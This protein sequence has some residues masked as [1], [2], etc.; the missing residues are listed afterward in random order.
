VIVPVLIGAGFIVGVVV[1]RWL[2]LAPAVG[3]GAWIAIVSELDEVPGWLLG[4]WYGVI[5]CVSIGAGIG[6]RRAI[7]R[8]SRT[9]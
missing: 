3:F 9:A 8:L 7:L 5:G 4:L 2:A 1:G 6:V